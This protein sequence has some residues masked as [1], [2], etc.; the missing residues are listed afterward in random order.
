[1]VLHLLS[2]RVRHIPCVIVLNDQGGGIMNISEDVV[3]ICCSVVQCLRHPQ[4]ES[5]VV[6]VNSYRRLAYV[7]T[8]LFEFAFQPPLLF[9]CKVLFTHSSSVPCRMS[10]AVPTFISV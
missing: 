5:L 2:Q 3:G 7:R 1:M 10:T 8:M 6:K 4:R 9:A